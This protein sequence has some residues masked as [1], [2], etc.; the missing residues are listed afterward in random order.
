MEKRELSVALNVAELINLKHV[1]PMPNSPAL[2]RSLLLASTLSFAA[3]V[4]LISSTLIA[5][6]L[7]S[8][9]PIGT[10]IALLLARKLV[11]FL[12]VFGSGDAV[13]GVVTIGFTCAVAGTLF[14]V[15]AFYRY[16]K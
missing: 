16:Q 2:L 8:Q 12:A 1:F 9:L 15:Y 14:D 13:E 3:P 4:V 11:D 5:L 7:V 10:E 6:W